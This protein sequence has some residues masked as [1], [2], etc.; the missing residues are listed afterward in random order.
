MRYLGGKWR[1][2]RRIVTAI[3]AD[4][5]RRPVHALELCSGAGGLTR[6]LADACDRVTAVEAHTGLVALLRNVQAGYVPPVV[7]TREEHAASTNP[8]D[9]LHAFRRFACSHGG[10]WDGYYLPDE[11]AREYATHRAGVPFTM[12]A[13]PYCHAASGSRA[14]VRD[15][16]ANITHVCGDALACDVP[17]DVDVIYCDPPYEGTRGYPCVAA[18]PDGAWWRRLSDLAT[19]T[20]VPTY[21]SEAREP[22]ANVPARLVLRH[23]P[24]QR[25]LNAGGGERI[26]LLWRLLPRAASRA[27]V[28]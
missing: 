10:A 16:R 22:P 9:P 21:M 14:L 8:T 18:A 26:E 5:G 1:I 12:H 4:V 24:G 27:A 25:R 15:S 2:A 23:A 19:T 3:V 6:L 20:G 11:P 13:A 7:V 28:R 17:D